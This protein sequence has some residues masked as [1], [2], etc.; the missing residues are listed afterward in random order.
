MWEYIE[1]A[2]DILKRIDTY[3]IP[4]TYIPVYQVM[5][6]FLFGLIFGPFHLAFINSLIWIITFEYLLRLFTRSRAHLYNWKYRIIAI[7]MNLLGIT[8]SKL[9]WNPKGKF[10]FL[11][12]RPNRSR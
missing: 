7:G 1:Y 4:D 3:A 11:L 2:K 8:I 5:S 9:I 6:A 12:P 10:I